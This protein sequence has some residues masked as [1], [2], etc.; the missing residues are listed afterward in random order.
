MH[1][2]ESF[3]ENKMLEILWDFE[4]QTEHLIQKGRPD[5]VIMNKE[6][7]TWDMVDISVPEDHS[8]VKIKESEKRDKYVDLAKEL[9]KKSMEYENDSDTNCKWCA[10]NGPKSLW[11]GIEQLKIGGRIKPSRLQYC[12]DRLEYREESRRSEVTCYQSDWNKRLSAYI[13]VKNSQVVW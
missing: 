1:K 2:L 7:I 6:K 3:Q 9:E 12:W 4:T 11:K 13:S 10:W 5:L 8:R